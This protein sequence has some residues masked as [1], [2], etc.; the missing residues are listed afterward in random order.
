[1]AVY[2]TLCAREKKKTH[3]VDHKHP[4]N[5]DKETTLWVTG[6]IPIRALCTVHFLSRTM[7][8]VHYMN[9]VRIINR[10]VQLQMEHSPGLLPEMTAALFHLI[11]D[12][13][14]FFFYEFHLILFAFATV[15]YIYY[16]YLHLYELVCK[17]S[18]IIQLRSFLPFPYVVKIV[19]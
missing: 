13:F 7:N 5:Q 16:R 9:N 14:F 6:Y 4:A 8:T 2:V 11:S 19:S 18:A 17:L 1:M 3:H 12:D 10:I 15:N